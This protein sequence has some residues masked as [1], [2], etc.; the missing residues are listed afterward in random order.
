[1]FGNPGFGT[2]FFNLCEK[3][4]IINSNKF[5]KSAEKIKPES[6]VCV[7]GEVVERSTETIN[8]ELFT[9]EIG[10]GEV[11]DLA[12][13]SLNTG[14]GQLAAVIGIGGT[15]GLIYSLKQLKDFI[16]AVRTGATPNASG[17][18]GGSGGSSTTTSSTKTS[19]LPNQ[20]T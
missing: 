12:W 10:I 19:Q 20:Q 8:K 7:L 13:E 4:L 18:G 1:M 15:T 6:V 9:G 14:I 5:F 3:I 17:T 16:N 11:A 2:F